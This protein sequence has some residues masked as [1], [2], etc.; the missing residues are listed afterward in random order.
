[1]SEYLVRNRSSL[2]VRRAEQVYDVVHL[3][4]VTGVNLDVVQL[5]AKQLRRQLWIVSAHE[6]H[7]LLQARVRVR[8]QRKAERNRYSEAEQLLQWLYQRRELGR[9]EAFLA[10]AES[11][12]HLLDQLQR[13]EH[14]R[15]GAALA[16]VLSAYQRQLHPQIWLFQNFKR[17]YCVRQDEHRTPN[18]ARR[19]AARYLEYV[20]EELLQVRVL[21][22]QFDVVI[23]PVNLQRVCVEEVPHV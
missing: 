5:L 19:Q 1:M 14:L 9:F 12:H 7:D 21:K 3:L 6:L 16:Q 22:L 8:V 23:L 20:L 2:R 11:A 15:Y 13:S 4:V 17:G 10:D 18:N